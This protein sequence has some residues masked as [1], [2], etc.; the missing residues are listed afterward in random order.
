MKTGDKVVCINNGS[1]DGRS[2][3]PSDRLTI[4]KIYNVLGY[5]DNSILI[6]ANHG[7]VSQVYKDRFVSLEEFRQDKLTILGI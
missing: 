1:V 6:V 5:L 4:G 3:L 2:C 7:K